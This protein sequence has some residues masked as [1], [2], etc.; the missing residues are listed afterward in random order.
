MTP[1]E[2]AA[3]LKESQLKDLARL[4]I[5]PVPLPLSRGPETICVYLLMA[6]GSP[7]LIDTGVGHPLALAR[8]AKALDQLGLDPREIEHVFLTHAHPDHAGGV[9]E[10]ARTYHSSVWVH[11]LEAPRLDGRQA[12][13]VREALPDVFKRLGVDEA[14]SRLTLPDLALSARAYDHQRFDGHLALADGQRLP[15]DGLELLVVHAPGHSPG[16][17]CFLER[18]HGILFSGDTLLSQ[19]AA[20]PTLS[21]DP[22]GTPYFQGLMEMQQ[23]LNLL[24]GLGEI[25]V[26]PGHGP[27]APLPGLVS[28]ARAAFEKK[29]RQLLRRIEPGATPYDLIRRRV[30]RTQGAYLLPDLYFT[31]CQLEVLEHEGLVCVEVDRG[32]ER[33][34]PTGE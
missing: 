33:V 14:M 15:V 25:L 17:V 26:L 34:L 12:R 21:L 18:G 3:A 9:V 31:R 1:T 28:Q 7:A 19:G 29:R 22:R 24:E 6:G 5:H 13:F 23:S 10:M 32:L 20:Q 30:E 2:S 16:S 27:P 8:L 11:P 4:G